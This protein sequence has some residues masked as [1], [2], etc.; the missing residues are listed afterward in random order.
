[1]TPEEITE[2][3][4]RFLIGRVEAVLSDHPGWTVKDL[5]EN[6]NTGLHNEL[7]FYLHKDQ[8][9]YPDDF[10]Y[11]VWDKKKLTDVLRTLEDKLKEHYKKNK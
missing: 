7:L 5:R 11:G 1:M 6:D 4:T 10:Y 8:K 9:T 3:K 2:G